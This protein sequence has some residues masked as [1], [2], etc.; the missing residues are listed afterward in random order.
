M[1]HEESAFNFCKECAIS[2]HLK[3]LIL[4]QSFYMYI[5]DEIIFRGLKQIR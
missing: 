3:E 2:L 1:A 4:E 5:L